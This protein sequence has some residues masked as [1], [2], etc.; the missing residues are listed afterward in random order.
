MA[1]EN[2]PRPERDRPKTPEPTHAPGEDAPVGRPRKQPYPV[3][4]PGIVDPGRTPG[5]EPDV[6]PVRSPGGMPV[7]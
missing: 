2:D 4:D 6:V 5:A 7:M 1:D 3:D